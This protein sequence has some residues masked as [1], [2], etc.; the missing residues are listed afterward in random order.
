VGR[1]TRDTP[2]NDP[3]QKF[4][5][6]D[7]QSR[8]QFCS[9]A[10]SLLQ[11]LPA[12]SSIPKFPWACRVMA[13]R[14]RDVCGLPEDAKL[15]KTGRGFIVR[16]LPWSAEKVRKIECVI[17]DSGVGRAEARGPQGARRGGREGSESFGLDRVD[18]ADT[19]RICLSNRLSLSAAE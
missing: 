16:D 8:Q 2:L 6:A 12:L 10:E 4:T 3:T 17:V 7:L 11:E 1:S 14:L 13:K 18:C 19:F 15:W 9:E 5:E